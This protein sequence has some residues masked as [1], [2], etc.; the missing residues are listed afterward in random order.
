[1]LNIVHSQ[2]FS[3]T[4]FLLYSTVQYCIIIPLGFVFRIVCYSFLSNILQI[5]R[6]NYELCN[7]DT[8][9]LM[10]LYERIALKYI[11]KL[12]YNVFVDFN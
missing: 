9:Y 11:D 2:N 12:P 10:Y 6:K 1:M 5:R 8:I 3:L 7:N 4:Q